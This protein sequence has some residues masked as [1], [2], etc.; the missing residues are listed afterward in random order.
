MGARSLLRCPRL[1]YQPCMSIAAA[2]ARP[3]CKS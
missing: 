1:K 3:T 2:P